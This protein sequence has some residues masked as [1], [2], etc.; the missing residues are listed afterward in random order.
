MS[1]A[2]GS[3]NPQYCH[4]HKISKK[5]LVS[6]FMKDSLGLSICNPCR[7]PGPHLGRLPHTYSTLFNALGP[8]F[9]AL[10][11]TGIQKTLF[12]FDPVFSDTS[13]LL[14]NLREGIK[15]LTARWAAIVCNAST[16][17]PRQEG[18]KFEANQGYIERLC[19]K[20]KKKNN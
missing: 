5:L 18:H 8:I 4:I 3:V 15:Q 6:S 9:K 17:R 20:K 7:M 16:Q 11:I 14:Q 2:L 19:L 13:L 12:C 10:C 1:K